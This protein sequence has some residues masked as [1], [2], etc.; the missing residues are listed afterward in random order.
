M[1]GKILMFR[2]LNSDQPIEVFWGT[3]SKSKFKI[4]KMH[5]GGSNMAAKIL[6]F[7]KANQT[8]FCL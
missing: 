5:N 4:A 6:I 8:E 7:C 1:K 2:Q 3:E